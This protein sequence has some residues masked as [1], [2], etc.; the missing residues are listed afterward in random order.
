MRSIIYIGMPQWAK[1]EKFGQ[2]ILRK[3]INIVAT[4]CHILKLK[5]TKIDFRWG[6]APSDP[7]GGAYSTPP[8]PLARFKKAYF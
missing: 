5:C 1:Y 2:L 3:I 8:G 6:F 7:A 4:R